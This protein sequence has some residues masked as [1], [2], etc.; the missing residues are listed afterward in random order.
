MKKNVIIILLLISSCGL[1]ETRIPEVPDLDNETFIPP[2]SADIVI[3]NFLTAF[4]TKNINNYCDCFLD[5]VYKFIPS[6]NAMLNYPVIFDV[7]KV[8]DERKYFLGLTNVLGTSNLMKLEFINIKYDIQS[9][10]SVVLFADYNIDLEL[11]GNI[12]TKYAGTISLTI[13][14]TQNGTWGISRWLDFQKEGENKPTFSELK[15]QYIII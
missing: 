4:N 2:T 10:D 7:W 13:I 3:E 6:A 12:D 8:A 15:A 1:F 9:S 5:S 14:P 11:I